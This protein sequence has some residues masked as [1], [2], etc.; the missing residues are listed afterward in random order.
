MASSAKNSLQPIPLAEK[1]TL[2]NGII[3]TIEDYKPQTEAFS[4]KERLGG[5][6][7][8]A[9]TVFILAT[10]EAFLGADAVFDTRL[11]TL[12]WIL[13]IFIMVTVTY[14]VY[15]FDCHKT[16]TTVGYIYLFLV[17][18]SML[19]IIAG[20][21]GFGMAIT[22]SFFMLVFI[23]MLYRLTKEPLLIIS[24]LIILAWVVGIT[25]I[26]LEIITADIIPL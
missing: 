1:P 13:V 6:L 18:F 23:C 3:N 2:K 5:I 17:I 15:K 12:L 4:K 9:A 14:S 19:S 20:R 21:I 26:Y 10:L 7:A 24:I 8:I 11:R 25:L 22:C 16:L